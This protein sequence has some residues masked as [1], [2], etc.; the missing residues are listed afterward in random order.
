MATAALR[1]ALRSWWILAF[2]VSCECL[3]LFVGFGSLSFA[4][5]GGRRAVQV[6]EQQ[7]LFFEEID[8]G[9]TAQVE[10]HI[11]TGDRVLVAASRFIK[12]A[13][14]SS[15]KYYDF[16][17]NTAFASGTDEVYCVLVQPFFLF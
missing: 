2:V 10:V 1:P 8:E 15:N 16:L 6:D 5:P 9:V 11:T 13:C 4:D 3:P 17:F 12:V 7:V 14:P